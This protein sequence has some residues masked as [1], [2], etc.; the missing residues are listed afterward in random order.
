MLSFN[1]LRVGTVAAGLLATSGA[2]SAAQAAEPAREVHI[3]PADRDD[4]VACDVQLRSQDPV[5]Y[6]LALFEG[7]RPIGLGSALGPGA[8][9]SYVFAVP[10]RYTPGT[11]AWLLEPDLV[12]RALQ[13]W[14]ESAPLRATVD[15]LGPAGR[16]AWLRAG[17]NQGIAVGDTFWLRIAG[18]PTARFDVRFVAPGL[19]WCSVEPLARDPAVR[20]GCEVAA[21]PAPGDRRAGRLG[22]AVSFVEQRSGQLLAWIAAPPPSIACPVEAHVDFFQSGQ[23]VGHG[24]VER[25]DSCF[26]YV[27]FTPLPAGA[28]AVPA[29]SPAASAPAAR[30]PRVGDDV[31]IRTIAEIAERCYTA[32]VFD[33]DQAG[34]LVNAGENDDL[35]LG[36]Q[37]TAYRDGVPVALLVVRRVQRSYSVCEARMTAL[38]EGA[39]ASAAELVRIGDEVRL[40]PPRP[41]PP[42]VGVIRAATPDGV[43]TARV[44]A[45]AAPLGA[46]L[47]VRRADETLAAAVLLWSD[48]ADAGGVV[49]TPSK[50]R[51]IE[52]GCQLLYDP[53][54]AE[55]LLP[56]PETMET[57]AS[58]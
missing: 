1:I 19:A 48:G 18:Q 41:S 32:R 29:S 22:S 40:V 13:E 36:Q 21:W 34:V 14:P 16:S 52:P 53:P 2:S 30:A 31:R 20:T 12:A 57:G 3:R 56:E 50:T 37:L 6:A 43:F 11:R 4:H 9:D 46:P 55:P 44:A 39:P 51:V 27:P 24:I 33:I 47:A 25:R 49:L 10:A 8:K 7:A 28:T 54:P 35:D 58:R 5:E 15:A 45:A 38:A 42:A 23:C 17:T 26:W